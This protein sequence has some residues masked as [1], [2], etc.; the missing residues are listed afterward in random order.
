MGFKDTDLYREMTPALGMV[1][2]YAS[3]AGAG[4]GF[5]NLY[6]GG[7][8]GMPRFLEDFG[9]WDDTLQAYA[10]PTPWQS[11]GTGAP[12]AGVAF[13]CLLSGFV[14][15]KLGR[16]KTF[17]LA[18]GI[19]I[20]GILVQVTSFK[21]FW[22]L[23]AGRII[24]ALS[25]G[26]ICNVVPTYQGEIAPARIRGAM[27]NFYQFWQLVG[28]LMATTANWGFQYRDDQ[29]SYRT[30]LILQFIIPIV[31][32]SAGLVLPES[33]RW[34]VEKGRVEQARKVLTLLR[35]KKAAPAIIE[36]E[37]ELLIKADAEQREFH[38]ATSWLD[39]FRG[40]NLRRTM[41]G[42]G[43]QSLQQAQGSSFISN[44]AITFM[45][46][47]G[48]KQN[49]MEMNV[50][51]SFVNTMGSTLAFY[52]VDKFGRRK[53]LFGGAIVLGSCMYTVAGVV[54]GA[55]GNT[56]AM[57]GVLAALFVWNFFQSFAWSSCVWITTAEVSTLQLR[58]K[59]MTVSTFTGFTVSVIVSFVAPYIQD[60]GYGNLQGKIGFLW[61]SFSVMSALWVYFFLPELKGRSLEELDELFEKRVGVFAF[62]KYEATGYGARLTKVE[63]LIAHGEVMEG[64]DVGTDADTSGRSSEGEKGAAGVKAL[65]T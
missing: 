51:F 10:I 64:V 35:G 38:A 60:A 61:G 4:F 45:Q 1:C 16:I 56:A 40:S 5:D 24:N 53:C 3:L 6:W 34:L 9:R 59:T 31:L 47:I 48:I 52:F 7:F 27:V 63:D 23:M 54:V 15:N 11:A 20:V 41:I 8:L 29:W 65:E 25:M 58:E 2:I 43:V 33:P 37:L 13:G 12:L 44:Y 57:K 39:C 28:A 14:G 55:P 21:N 26:V 30:T 49:H 62:G 36:E 18:G 46:A 50:L 32:I 17:F 22:Q 19:A 42:A